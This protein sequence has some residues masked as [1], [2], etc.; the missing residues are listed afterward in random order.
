M[1]FTRFHDD[2]AR[3]EKSLLETTY[4]GIYQLN[5]PGNGKTVFVEGPHIRIQRGGGSNLQTNPF[6][7]NESLRRNKKLVQY[8]QV[9]TNPNTEKREYSSVSFKVD[10]TRASLPAWTFREKPQSR[11][12]FLFMDPQ[13]NLWFKFDNNCPTRMLEK[14]H[15]TSA[16]Y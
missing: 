9:C 3:I 11:K 14:D 1:A 12:D 2:P 7:I 8:D 6:E 5:T 16:Y 13:S 15:Y 4:T 10:E